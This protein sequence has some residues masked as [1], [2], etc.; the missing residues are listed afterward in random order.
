MRESEQVNYVYVV[1]SGEFEVYKRIEIHA[2]SP[3]EDEKMRD[4]VK[5]DIDPITQ[6]Q[7]SNTSRKLPHIKKI[8]LALKD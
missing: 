3:E 8:P 4:K 5:Q 7:Q 2:E 1:V 6:G